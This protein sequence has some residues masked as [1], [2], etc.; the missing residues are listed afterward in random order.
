MNKNIIQSNKPLSV[1]LYNSSHDRSLQMAELVFGLRQRWQ[2]LFLRRIRSPSKACSQLDEATIRTLVSVL[3]AEEQVT[4]LQQPTGIGQRPRPMNS[5]EAPQTASCK[6]AG[7][8]DPEHPEE[9]PS[10]DRCVLAPSSGRRQRWRLHLMCVC[11]FPAGLGW[12]LR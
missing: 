4:G 5:D 3:S 6:S 9:P 8:R 11:V 2:S 10:P 12:R 1:V 7:R